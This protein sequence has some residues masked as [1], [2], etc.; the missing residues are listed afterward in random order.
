MQ[1]FTK[2]FYLEI[3]NAFIS[4]RLTLVKVMLGSVSIY[5]FSLFQMS[6]LIGKALEWMR[7]RFFLGRKGAGSDDR[8]V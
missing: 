5:Y 8:V 4:G 2:T 1:D 3:H 7:L 6:L